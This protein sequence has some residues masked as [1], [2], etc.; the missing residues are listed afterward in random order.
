MY[1]VKR[2]LAWQVVPYAAL[3]FIV[4]A[5]NP[6]GSTAPAD[7]PDSLSQDFADSVQPLNI[8]DELGLGLPEVL[9]SG[10]EYNESL[11]NP[12]DR[13]EDY[14]LSE[15]KSAQNLGIYGADALY[16]ALYGKTQ[17]YILY[18]D[19]CERLRREIGV[20]ENFA[21]DLAKRLEENVGNPDSIYSILSESIVRSDSVLKEDGQDRIAAL[22]AAGCL[23]ES[24]HIL[25]TSYLSTGNASPESQKEKLGAAIIRQTGSVATVNGRLGALPKDK[26]LE[27]LMGNFSRLESALN[28]TS[29]G[30]Q[31]TDKGLTKRS[32]G[33]VTPLVEEIRKY[34]VR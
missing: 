16:L 3:A 33:D 19:A 30:Q 1:A 7:S 15:D 11:T 23:I 27:W 26:S 20:R 8:R 14:L 2:N 31:P 34:M 24:L 10:V 17:D 22:M 6:P 18:S 9:N 5:C 21:D 28:A 25:C 12:L 32:L 13:V 4:F 29:T